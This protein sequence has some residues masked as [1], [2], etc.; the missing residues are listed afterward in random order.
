LVL[1]AVAQKDGGKKKKDPA[2]KYP[3]TGAVIVKANLLVLDQQ[4]QYIDDLKPEDV[5]LFE[6]GVPQKLIRIEKKLPPMHVGLVVDNSGSLRTY[7]DQVVR[8]SKMI[9][10]NLQD[11]DGS[12]VVRFVSNDVIEVIQDHTT[13]KKDLFEAIDNLYIEGGQSAVLDAVYL[14]A[15]KVVQWEK[16]FPNHKFAIVLI[17][18]GEDRASYYDLDQTLA[19][20]AGSGLQVFPLFFT[21]QL[22]DKRSPGTGEKFGLSNSTR[23]AQV[24]A[25]RTGGTASF[26]PAKP[27]DDA[28]LQALKPTFIELR[29]QYV[30]S[31]ESTNQKRDGL[32]RKLTVQ[33]ADD[34]NGT[35]RRGLIRSSFVVPID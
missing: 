35:K 24:L 20:V 10:T 7:I 23:L 8:V 19:A 3:Q 14:A 16:K 28:L 5:K 31:Y 1:T 4:D 33:I 11:G 27:T 2:N 13:N 25:L 18:D 9:I 29:S 34:L 30:L 15:E 12:F 32:E 21:G 17:T 6:D 22:T 26:L